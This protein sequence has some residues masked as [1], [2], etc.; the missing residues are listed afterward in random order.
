MARIS[1]VDVGVV[2]IL[3][4]A[5]DGLRRAMM[6]KNN[7]IAS[8]FLGSDASVAAAPGQGVELPTGQ[9]L[10]LEGDCDAYWGV[11][12]AGI[13]QVDVLEVM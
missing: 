13:Q 10:S 3:V 11:C 4:V 1:S 8:I 2:P 9:Q 5:A 12:A 6:I 7:G